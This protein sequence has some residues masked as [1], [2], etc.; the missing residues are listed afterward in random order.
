MLA[1]LTG[2]LLIASAARICALLAPAS[3]L[4]MS[5]FD[6]SE[7]VLVRAAFPALVER[8]SFSEEGWVSLVLAHL[9]PR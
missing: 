4:V 7:R 1:N 8:A 5:G 2:G 9:R 3:V 6:E